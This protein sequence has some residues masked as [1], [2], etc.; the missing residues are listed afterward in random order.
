MKQKLFFIIAGLCIISFFSCKKNDDMPAQTKTLL[1]KISYQNFADE[2]SYDSDFRL[3]GFI[4]R[5][6]NNPNDYNLYTFTRYNT[7]GQVEEVFTTTATGNASKEVYVYNS[8]GKKERIDQYA[9]GANGFEI[10]TQH[11]YTYTGNTVVVK[12][13]NI[14]NNTILN[15]REWT[16][17]NAGNVILTKIYN[18]STGIL[19]QQQEFSDFDG[20]KDVNTL[21]PQGYADFISKENYRALKTTLYNANGTV[22]SVSNFTFTYEYDADGYPTKRTTAGG[23]SPNIITYT[24]KKIPL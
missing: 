7:R 4:R 13:K 1:T 19:T 22:N 2:L 10:F 6:N 24:Y 21:F 15:Y 3:T 5:I 23:N 9:E 17:D 20:R 18:F 14:S 8:E 11:L 12:R 16:Y